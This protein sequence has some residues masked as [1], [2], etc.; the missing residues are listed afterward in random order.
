M[1]PMSNWLT[2][3]MVILKNLIDKE[4]AVNK[5]NLKFMVRLFQYIHR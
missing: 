2:N 3:L 1:W 4:F 5:N